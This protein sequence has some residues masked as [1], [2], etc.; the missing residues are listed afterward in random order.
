MMISFAYV[1]K[2]PLHFFFSYIIVNANHSIKNQEHKKTLLKCMYAHTITCMYT[3]TRL[4]L[5]LGTADHKQTTSESR[6]QEAPAAGQD[7]SHSPNAGKCMCIFL[8]VSL[9]IEY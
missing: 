4:F 8:F 9:L 2:T 3:P 1:H 5:L 7:S 6:R